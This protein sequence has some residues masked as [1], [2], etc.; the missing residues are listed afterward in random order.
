MK[1]LFFRRLV[2]ALSSQQVEYKVNVLF[3][4]KPGTEK[5][6]KMVRTAGTLGMPTDKIQERVQIV[7]AAEFQVGM[8][9]IIIHRI[10]L[11]DTDFTPSWR[12]DKMR[13]WA[14]ETANM[15]G[16]ILVKIVYTLDGQR[17]RDELQLTTRF[18]ASQEELKYLALDYMNRCW[19][20]G[21]RRIEL[22]E[23]TAVPYDEQ[24]IYEDD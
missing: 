6:Q 7:L 20:G 23:V 16:V 19:G 14:R 8:N 17:H 12:V 13:E 2:E 9:D 18:G 1:T 4:I 11:Q 24:D 21:G 3:T 10:A 5:H 15:V 22:L